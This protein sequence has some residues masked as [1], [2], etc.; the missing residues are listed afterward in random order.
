[1]AQGIERRIRRKALRTWLAGPRGLAKR[2]ATPIRAALRPPDHGDLLKRV[3]RAEANL[4][5][6]LASRYAQ[7]AA[8]LP[9]RE[10]LRRQEFSVYSQNGEDGLLLFLFSALGATDR[11]FVE[12]GIGNVMECN[13]TNLGLGFG[14]GGLLIDYHPDFVETARRVYGSASGRL[15][16]ARSLITPQYPQQFPA[17]L[18][19]SF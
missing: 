7:V 16:V 6:L 13:T 1:M 19:S 18:S 5:A 12:F 3:A 10:L 15:Q 8:D 4:N 9:Q 2:I 14:W 17:G 11:R